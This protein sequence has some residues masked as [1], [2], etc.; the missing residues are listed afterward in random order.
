MVKLT[1]NRFE[2][3]IMKKK[4][5]SKFDFMFHGLRRRLWNEAIIA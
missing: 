4:C 1:L 2:S 5:E 3:V